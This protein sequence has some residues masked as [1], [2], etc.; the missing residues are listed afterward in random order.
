MC[1][2]VYIYGEVIER[3]NCKIIITT[4]VLMTPDGLLHVSQLDTCSKQQEPA[5]EIGLSQMPCSNFSIL[6]IVIGSD[7]RGM[8]FAN[9]WPY[10][11]AVLTEWTGKWV[12]VVC[13]LET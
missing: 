12:K 11:K 3:G 10:I 13:V 5:T 9:W 8:E 7:K 1:V 6:R 2:C 4:L